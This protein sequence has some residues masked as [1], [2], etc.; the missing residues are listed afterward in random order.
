M[1][2]SRRREFPS[3]HLLKHHICFHHCTSIVVHTQYAGFPCQLVSQVQKEVG[4]PHL[5]S[6]TARNLNLSVMAC[7]LPLC[8]PNNYTGRH[9]KS[10]DTNFYSTHLSHRVFY[11]LKCLLVNIGN[12][13]D[14][15]DLVNN[16]HRQSISKA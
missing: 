15:L 12:H 8:Y 2:I 9:K 5:T 7:V 3:S 6:H 4:D 10:K 1:E 13:I 16:F 14:K 11:Q